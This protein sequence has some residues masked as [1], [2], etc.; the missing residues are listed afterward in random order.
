[1]KEKKETEIKVE[2]EYSLDADKAQS[3]GD[4]TERIDEEEIAALIG[5]L[6]TENG[7]LR[8]QILRLAAEFDN[9]R[10]RTDR[11]MMNLVMNANTE[12]ISHLLPLL[13]DLDRI[14]L[15]TEDGVDADALLKGAKLFQKN[16]MKILQDEGLQQ[17]NSIGEPFDPEKHDAL[18]HISEENKEQNIVIDEHKKGY[19]FKDKVIRH[20][21]VI[22]SK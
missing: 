8:D 1:M 13:D 21:Q 4:G 7:K 5:D 14:V 10:K 15:A 12:L 2:E 22:V 16:L 3:S 19:L 18:L 9:F 17:M 11:D 20:A 6:K